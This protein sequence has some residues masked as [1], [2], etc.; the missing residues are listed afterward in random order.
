[1]DDRA[2]KTDLRPTKTLDDTQRGI[3]RLALEVINRAVQDYSAPSKGRDGRQH[4]EE[5]RKFLAGEGT[6]NKSAIT[7]WCGAGGIN[8]DA[9]QKAHQVGKYAEKE[10]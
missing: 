6:G 7:A 3:S 2:I 1:M 5:A 10:G 4:R 8:R 9:L